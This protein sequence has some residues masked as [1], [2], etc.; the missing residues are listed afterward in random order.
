[1]KTDRRFSKINTWLSPSDPSANLNEA[2]AKRHEG[3]GSWFLNCQQFK[4]WKSGSRRYLWLH[5]IPGCG[6]TVLCSTIIEHLRQSKEDS[7]HTILDFFFDFK[8]KEKQ[9]LNGLVRSLVA[10]LY[11]VC[12]HSR[13]ELDALYSSCEDGRRQPTLESLTTTFQHMMG[14]AGKI[15][16]AIDALDE[17]TTRRD[18]LLWMEKLSGFRPTKLY[19]LATSRREE[20]IE[21]ELKRWLWQDNFIS[22][23][24]DS[25]NSDIRSYIRKR[26]REDYKFERW[27][28]NPSVQDEI[29]TELM[30]KAGGM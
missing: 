11:S 26:L 1:M 3:T 24:Q 5:G 15:Q 27:H 21:S 13:K 25:V 9:T 22:I 18:L 10:Q 23:Q 2:I 28:S 30:K 12:E 20:E 17:C 7:S 19:L 6:K 8:D 4:E 14:H 16:I 29:E